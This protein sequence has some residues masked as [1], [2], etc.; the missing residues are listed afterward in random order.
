[1][2][3]SILSLAVVALLGFFMNSCGTEV[4]FTG[5]DN[6]SVD[7]GSTDADVI[8]LVTV[9]SGKEIT[10]TGIDYDKAGEQNAT[11][12]AGDET[13]DAI[14]KI[15]TDKLA[16]DYEYLFAGDQEIS[17]AEIMQSATVYN[18]ILIDGFLEDASLEAICVGNV[19]TFTET[20]LVSDEFTGVLTGTGIFEKLEGGI[21]Q[22]KMVTLTVEWSDDTTETAVL[23]FE[24]K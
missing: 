15:K 4:M 14:I 17:E 3:K 6:L 8:A 2:K 10:V 23:T 7:L 1:M 22:V 12:V 11:F 20:N 16:G 21:Y 13:Q 19:L 9:S 18:K 5:T 24:K